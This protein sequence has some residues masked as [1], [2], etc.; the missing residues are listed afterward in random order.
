MS[1]SQHVEKPATAPRAKRIVAKAAAKP[2][3]PKAK[4]KTPVQVLFGGRN[5]DTPLLVF[6]Y[7]Q[8]G[9][10]LSAVKEMLSLLALYQDRPAGDHHRQLS[11][12]CPEDVEQ[13][14]VRGYPTQPAAEHR[15]LPV[16]PGA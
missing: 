4:A 9:V 14:Q 16:R 11:A 2:A 3:P 7:T 5:A 13:E 15:S 12:N 8:E 6:R 10:E 1:N